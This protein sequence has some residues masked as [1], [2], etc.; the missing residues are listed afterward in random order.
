MHVCHNDILFWE[1]AFA[2]MRAAGNFEN[3]ER[4][5]CGVAKTLKE[6]KE[7]LEAGFEYVTERDGLKIYRKRK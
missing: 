5:T 4:Y 3:P 1:K 2:C 6:D 7:F